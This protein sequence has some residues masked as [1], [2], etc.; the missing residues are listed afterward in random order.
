MLSAWRGFFP[1]SRATAATPPIPC[2]GLRAPKRA[3]DAAQGAVARE[4]A[5]SCSSAGRRTTRWR[6]RD[7]AM[8]ELLYSS[9]LRLAELVGLDLAPATAAD[10]ERAK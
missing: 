1:G 2:V 10:R 6:S 3:Q 7:K 8:F 5:R 4:A 9:G